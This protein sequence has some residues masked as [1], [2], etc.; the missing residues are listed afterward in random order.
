MSADPTTDEEALEILGVAEFAFL[1]DSPEMFG[2]K[3][4]A[5][6]FNLTKPLAGHPKG[7]TLMRE[8][9]LDALRRCKLATAAGGGLDPSG[10]ANPRL[11]SQTGGNQPSGAVFDAQ[12]LRRASPDPADEKALADNR[13]D[14]YFGGAP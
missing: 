7:S 6:M 10:A 5:H 11:V 3:N 14:A 4:P 1:W 12:R 8:T 9:I 2:E 13:A